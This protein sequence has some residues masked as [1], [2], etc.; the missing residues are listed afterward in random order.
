MA[1]LHDGAMVPCNMLPTMVM[2]KIGSTPLRDA[3]LLGREINILRERYETPVTAIPGCGD[4]RYAGFCTGGCP[5]AVFA[6]HGTLKAVDEENCYKKYLE[7][8]NVPL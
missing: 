2:G 8:K 1:I 4:C 5:A 7:E 3:W 6:R